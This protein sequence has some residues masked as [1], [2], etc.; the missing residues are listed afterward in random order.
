M[1]KMVVTLLELLNMLKA[2]EDLIKKEN[3]TVML[4]EKSD[5]SLKLKP[6]GKNFKRKGSQSFNKAQGDKVNKDTEKKKAKG[7]C[8]HYGKPGHWK[9]N[10]RHYLASLKNDKPAEGVQGDPKAK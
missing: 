4:A 5:S 9:R 6:K 2:A 7:N 8:F 3:T 10:C 1:N